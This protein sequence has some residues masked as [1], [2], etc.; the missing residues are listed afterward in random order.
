MADVYRSLM[1]NTCDAHCKDG[2]RFDVIQKPAAALR[3][4]S[5]QIAIWTCESAKVIKRHQ[6]WILPRLGDML[7]VT[8]THRN[9]NAHRA[10]GAAP[11]PAPWPSV[12]PTI[13]GMFASLKIGRPS[14]Q[15]ASSITKN[16]FV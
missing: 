3:Y 1:L 9:A 15:R 5:F 2:R 10:V 7:S 12:V 14:R 6:R 11:A 4:S 8:A 16:H 13:S